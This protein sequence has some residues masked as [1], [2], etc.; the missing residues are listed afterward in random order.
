MK[1]RACQSLL[2]VVGGNVQGGNSQIHII[3]GVLI[4]KAFAEAY[5]LNIG[6]PSDASDA[7]NVTADSQELTVQPGESPAPAPSP[8][9]TKSAASTAV[10]ALLAAPALL[11]MLMM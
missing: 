8:E 4:P 7:D 6:A 10:A 3:D 11:A 1:G 5:N 9:P 2:L